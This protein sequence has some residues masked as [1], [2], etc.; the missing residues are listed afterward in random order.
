[1]K[2]LGV[3]ANNRKKSF[4]VQTR[5]GTY[6]FPFAKLEIRPSAD[7]PIKEVFPD[8]ELG[9][10]GF[11]YRLRSGAEDTVHVD[12]V[13]EYNRDSGYLSELLLHEL[14]VEALKALEES[15]LSKRK[16]I[17]RLGTSP[18]QFYRLLDPT[19][20]GKS[21][22]QMLALLHLLGKEVDLVVRAS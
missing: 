1:V 14:T 22:G 3:E 20:Y 4:E 9:M 19:Y 15:G 11:T 5:E 2:I 6:S 8:E 17:R 21:A 12:A 10:E 13:L 16:L 18:S 7:D